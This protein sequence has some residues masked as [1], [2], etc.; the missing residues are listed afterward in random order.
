MVR[1]PDVH[2]NLIDLN[3][4]ELV[5]LARW[6]GLPASRGIPR[7][8]IMESLETFT[9][10]DVTI[11]FDDMRITVS[12]WLGRHYKKVAMQLAK[13]VCPNCIGNCGDLQVLDC[14]TMNETNIT[15][16]AARR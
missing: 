10:V 6:C 11:P 1:L 15:G 12:T 9:P 4:T 2:I 16:R 5:L 13:N 7:E 3:H 14:Y 8:L